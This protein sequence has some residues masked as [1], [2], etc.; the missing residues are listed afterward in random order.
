MAPHPL[1]HPRRCARRLTARPAQAGVRVAL[2]LPRS[3]VMALH[4]ASFFRP[5]V[6]PSKAKASA[7]TASID[8]QCSSGVAGYVVPPNIAGT[9]AVMPSVLELLTQRRILLPRSRP[10]GSQLKRQ[11]PIFPYSLSCREPVFHSMLL[12]CATFGSPAC[13]QVMTCH[14]YLCFWT[15][16][17]GLNAH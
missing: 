9:A 11:S 6:A 16:C 5:G 4:F 2:S 1:R 8:V 14:R 10:G 17:R 13:S 7:R 15:F 3:F 12:S